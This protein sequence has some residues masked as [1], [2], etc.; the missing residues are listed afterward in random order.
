M[1][2]LHPSLAYVAPSE[3]WA[4]ALG[5]AYP[6]ATSC[7]RAFSAMDVWAIGGGHPP[8]LVLKRTVEYF[9]RGLVAYFYF[10]EAP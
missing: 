4:R 6:G 7:C 9:L 2:G 10:G 1:E 8:K 3:L 5:R